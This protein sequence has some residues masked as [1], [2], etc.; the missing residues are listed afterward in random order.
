MFGCFGNTCIHCVFVSFLLCIFFLICCQCKDYCHRVKTIAVN[1]NNNNK[2]IPRFHNSFQDTACS[3]KCSP[4]HTTDCPDIWNIWVNPLGAHVQETFEDYFCFFLRCDPTR[5]MASFLRFSRSHTTT[6]HSRQDSSGRVISSSQRHLPHNIHNTHNRQMSMPSVGFEPTNS[7]GQR[8]QTYVLDSA[9]TGTGPFVALPNKLC[10]VLFYT[11][12]CSK[13]LN[14]ELNPICYLLAL[15]G[16]HH[17]LHVSR[18]RVKLLTFKRLIS[19]IYMEHPFLM[20]LD[21]TQ[22]RSTVGRTPLDE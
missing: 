9:A 8:P 2:V 17:F 14:P 20:F 4:I 1:N 16:A 7:A 10:T 21:H 22:R 11:C 18:I 13:T 12:T 5:F 6:H 15:L 3:Q 19:Y